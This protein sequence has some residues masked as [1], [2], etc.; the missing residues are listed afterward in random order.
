MPEHSHHGHGH[1]PHATRAFAL[2]TLINLGYTGVEALIGWHAGSLALL[3]DALHN[4][5]DVLG[6]ALAW[7]AAA[8]AQRAPTA[9]HTYGWRRATQLSPLA[10][11]LLLVGFS[12]A[13]IGEALRRL[14]APPEVAGRL[15][16]LVAAVGVLVNPKAAKGFGDLVA[17]VVGYRFGKY[18]YR[19]VALGTTKT[20]TRSWE[21]T[22]CLW[23]ITFAAVFYFGSHL[24]HGQ[25][26]AALIAMPVIMALAEAKSPHTWDEPVMMGAALL[27]SVAILSFIPP[28]W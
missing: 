25:F 10:N 6:L 28:I 14:A 11:A 23:L 5:G 18:R 21:G 26:I 19:T 3:S 7:A 12:G 2:G 17:G 27:T 1:A 24:P 4:L 20:Y 15:V 16:M 8:L 13:L 9:R 22:A